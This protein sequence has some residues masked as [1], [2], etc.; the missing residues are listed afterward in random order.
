MKFAA[1]FI[2]RPVATS[3]LMIG[4]LL[5]GLTAFARLP[6]ASLPAVDR[7]TIIVNAPLPGASPTT[8]ATALAQPLESSI[9]LLPG[10]V[11]MSSFSATGGRRSAGG[12][13]CGGTE[14]A[15]K[16]WLAAVLL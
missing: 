3:L 9:G 7:P 8:V 14:F 1:L 5:L 12:D 13:Q 6:I 4:V 15:E 10:I 11:E 2:L 16:L